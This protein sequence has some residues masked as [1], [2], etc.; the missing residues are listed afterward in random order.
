[1][2]QAEFER[3]KQ[4]IGRYAQELAAAAPDPNTLSNWLTL[5]SLQIEDDAWPPQPDNAPLHERII[6]RLAECLA[7]LRAGTDDVLFDEVLA[8]MAAGA[9][10]LWAAVHEGDMLA[11]D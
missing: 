6:P 5:A 3:L 7:K 10:E 8:E 1:M 2:K 4:A 11:D 9:G